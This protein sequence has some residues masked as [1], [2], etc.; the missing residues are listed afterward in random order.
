[1]TQTTVT[2]TARVVV[3]LARWQQAAGWD[4]RVASPAGEPLI[5]WL[6]D[7]GIPHER[8]EAARGPGPGTPLE[9]VRLGRIIRRASPDLLHLHSSKAGMAGRAAARGSR[10]TIFQPHAWS[11]VAVDG[12]ARRAAV[13][14]E[15][16]AARWADVLLCVS[17]GER[18]RGQGAGVD[19]RYRV[20]PNG[21]DLTR[22]VPGGASTRADARRR[23]GLDQAPL[24]VCIGRLSPQKGQDLLVSAWTT[25]RAAVPAARLVLVGGGS[26]DVDPIPPGVVLAGE[27]HDVTGWLHAADVVVAPSRWEGMALGVLEAMASA[28]SV[29]ATDVEGMREAIGDGVA[30]AIVPPEDAAALARAVAVRLADVARADEEGEAGRHRAEADF[31][32]ERSISAMA[33]LAS[34][35]LAARGR[36]LVGSGR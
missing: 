4:V 13:F 20:V 8:W 19:G 33:A 11:F 30:G 18:R 32:L 31:D 34:E 22:F 9:V 12:A 21:V 6:R 10:P 26:L 36:A 2:G 24:A 17:D 29:V 5:G 1:M 15:R 23:L 7:T 28:R 25:V 14:W 3:D 35:V 27:Q 16:V